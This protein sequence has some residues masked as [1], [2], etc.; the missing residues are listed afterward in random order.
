M[1]VTTHSRSQGDKY[2]RA[3]WKW[4]RAACVRSSCLYLCRDPPG[5][6]CAVAAWPATG[7]PSRG[8]ARLLAQPGP[9]CGS[10]AA[11]DGH[12]HPDGGPW[13]NHC[14]LTGPAGPGERVW[15]G[16][17]EVVAPTHSPQLSPLPSLGPAAAPLHQGRLAAPDDCE[18]RRG[19]PHEG[20]RHQLPGPWHGCA[21]SALAG[22][23]LGQGRGAGVLYACMSIC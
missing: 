15:P 12:S 21:G 22:G 23:R 10:P 20:G 19:S 16:L 13:N 5:E 7:C 17:R 11:V 2:L 1:R 4:V 6:H 3:G 14:D 9:E 8:P 18:N